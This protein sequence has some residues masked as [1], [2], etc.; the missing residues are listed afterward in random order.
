MI[1]RR[2]ALILITATATVTA[3]TPIADAE[4]FLQRINKTL[5]G[6]GSLCVNSGMATPSTPSS[7]A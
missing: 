3:I 4:G 6:G 5:R 7:S 1:T 2:D